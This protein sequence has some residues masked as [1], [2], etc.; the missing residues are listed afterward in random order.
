MPVFRPL[1]ERQ[2]YAKK[3]AAALNK[4]GKSLKIKKIF[5][6]RKAI[7]NSPRHVIG[8]DPKILIGTIKKEKRER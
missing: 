6:R 8:R 1:Y 5:G 4:I 7:I 3:K 2:L